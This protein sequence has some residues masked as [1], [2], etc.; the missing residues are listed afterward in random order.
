MASGILGPGI[1]SA[2]I[3]LQQA[4][5]SQ[6]LHQMQSAQGADQTEKI[7]K[8]AQEFEALLLTGWL[9]EAEKSLAT[10]PGADDGDDDS[11]AQ[12][13][14]T[15]MG[16]QSLAESLAA[17]GGIGIG[18]MIAKAMLATAQKAQEKAPLSGAEIPTANQHFPLN[19]GS[20]NAD[21]MAVSR[22][23]PE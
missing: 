1:M 22:K 2:Q 6:L 12:G 3:G 17:S 7:K 23:G 10:V 13:T 4:K 19:S 14:M 18:N 20:Q 9:Q 11:G 21:R 15:S 5:E 16:V 8:G